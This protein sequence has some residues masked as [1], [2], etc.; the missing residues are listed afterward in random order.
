MDKWNEIIMIGNELQKYKSKQFVEILNK[1]KPI[2]VFDEKLFFI[3]IEK[4]TVYDGKKIIVT[5]LDG[6]EIEVIVE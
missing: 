1:A 6:V 3:F 4:M 2:K 5:L